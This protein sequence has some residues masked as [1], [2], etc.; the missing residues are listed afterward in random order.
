MKAGQL[1]K[2]GGA[3]V[4]AQ[5]AAPANVYPAYAGGS[6]SIVSALGAVGERDT[7]FNHRARIAAANG[8]GGYR[9]TANQNLQMVR[10]LKQGQL[11]RA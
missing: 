10:L 3:P 11:K 5:P 6:D 4:A 1:V 8:I 9:G 2:V 7:S